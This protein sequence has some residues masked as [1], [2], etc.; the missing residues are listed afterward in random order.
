MAVR[1]R[2]IG[3]TT[4]PGS[5]DGPKCSIFEWLATTKQSRGE[6]SI[7]F[8]SPDGE[9]GPRVYYAEPLLRLWVEQEPTRFLEKACA[10]GYKVLAEIESHS[11]V[12]REAYKF[13]QAFFRNRHAGHI[14]VTNRFLRPADFIDASPDG[15]ASLIIPG[16]PCD[17]GTVKRTPDESVHGKARELLRMV[18]TPAGVTTSGRPWTTSSCSPPWPMLGS[19]GGCCRYTASTARAARAARRAAPGRASIPE[20]PAG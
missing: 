10:F 8:L 5:P 20:R 11:E 14:R 2:K 7:R 6:L 16:M 17:D 13:W 19:G 18:L 9:D 12:D 3:E 15:E 4:F 1:F